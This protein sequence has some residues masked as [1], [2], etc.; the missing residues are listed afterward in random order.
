MERNEAMFEHV[1]SGEIL[2]REEWERTIAEWN[3]TNGESIKF[4]S[5]DFIEV[6]EVEDEFGDKEWVRK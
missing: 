1:F 5:R 4:N 6:V 2:S 3:Q